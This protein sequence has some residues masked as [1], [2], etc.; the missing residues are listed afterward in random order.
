MSINENVCTTLS[1]VPP[2][3][4]LDMLRRLVHESASAIW[5][6][7]GALVLGDPAE[8]AVRAVPFSRSQASLNSPARAGA[9]DGG[10]AARGAHQGRAGVRGPAHARRVARR[11]GT[12]VPALP[13]AL[14]S[15]RCA[16]R[17]P[18]ARERA[19]P[20]TARR[21]VWRVCARRIS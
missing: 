2:A 20:L 21:Y 5:R 6:R 12:G 15:R 4:A 16:H 18:K 14:H 8:M 7:D 11:G 9:G 1:H 13:C 17:V 3:T 10:G 19:P